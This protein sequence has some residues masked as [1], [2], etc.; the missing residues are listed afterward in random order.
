MKKYSAEDLMEKSVPFIPGL[1]L[2][3][4]DCGPIKS[5]QINGAGSAGGA[6]AQNLSQP[7]LKS[8]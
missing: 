8:I 5:A 6:P 2:L 1:I 7:T 3:L 4:S